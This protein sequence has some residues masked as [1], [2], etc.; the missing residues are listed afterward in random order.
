MSKEWNNQIKMTLSHRDIEIF[1]AAL[2]DFIKRLKKNSKAENIVFGTNAFQETVEYCE[3]LERQLQAALNN[4]Q[5][6][7]S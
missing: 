5:L 6:V 4:D 2:P 7:I 3:G 1:K